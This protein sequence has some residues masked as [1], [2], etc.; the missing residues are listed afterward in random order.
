MVEYTN[1][2]GLHACTLAWRYR[3]HSCLGF[4]GDLCLMNTTCHMPLNIMDMET[5]LSG[6]MYMDGIRI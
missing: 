1:I 4:C 3:K 2:H 5:P 6:G